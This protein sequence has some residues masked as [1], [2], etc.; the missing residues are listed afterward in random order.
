MDDFY[1]ARSSTSPP[2]PWSNFAPPFSDRAVGIFIVPG[3]GSPLNF[4]GQ[5]PNRQ[6][7]TFGIISLI[8]GIATFFLGPIGIV[9]VVIAIIFGSKGKEIG[10]DLPDKTG[11]YLSVAGL[12]L[13]AIALLI[14]L[15]AL[16]A[17]AGLL[18]LASGLRSFH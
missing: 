3:T 16:T 10:A 4:D 17:C 6:A 5:D 15:L 13:A 7:M 2:L 9:T 11:Y 1:A 18:G 12:V 14:T 8:C